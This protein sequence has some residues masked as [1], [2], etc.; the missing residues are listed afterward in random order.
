MRK[1]VLIVGCLLIAAGLAV[2]VQAISVAQ[3]GKLVVIV[4][5]NESYTNIVGNSQAPY[6]NQLISQGLLFTNYTARR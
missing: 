5:E 3:S 1:L 2:V 6:L 4:E